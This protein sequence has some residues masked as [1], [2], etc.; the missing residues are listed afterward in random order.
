VDTCNKEHYYYYYYYYSLHALPWIAGR[1]E[2]S[3]WRHV[4]FNMGLIR[5]TTSFYS[6][7]LELHDGRLPRRSV[8]IILGKQ[9]SKNFLVVAT[10]E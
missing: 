7:D 8:I 1:R 4:T 2:D 3:K 9:K 10:V 6:M 5:G